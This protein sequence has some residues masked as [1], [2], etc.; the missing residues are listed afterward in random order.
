[1]SDYNLT[2][3]HPREFE[4]LTQSL[5]LR[6]ISSGVTPF[7]DGRDGGRE[8]TYTGKMM[9]PSGADQWDGYLVI[10]SKFLTRPTGDTGKDGDWVIEQL[11]KDLKKFEDPKRNLPKPEYYLLVTNVVLTPVH[12]VGSKDRVFKLLGNYEPKIGLKSYDVW[13]YDK[14]CRILDGQPEI[15]QRY[16]GF[17][18]TGDVLSQMAAFLQDQ[19]PDFSQI[20]SLFLQKELRSDQFVKLEQAGHTADQKTSLAHVFVDLPAFDQLLVEPPGDESDPNNLPAGIVAEILSAGSQMLKGSSFV[21][22][23]LLPSEVINELRPQPGRFV[24]VGGPGQGKSTIGQ[25]ICQLYRAAILKDQPPH[26]ISA[27][28]RTTLDLIGH[29]CHADGKGLPTVRRFP[30]RVVLDQFAN[31]L[32][33]NKVNS[34]LSYIVKR[35]NYLT[36]RMISPDDLRRWLGSYPWLI[37]LDGLDEVPATSNRNEVLEKIVEFWTEA[38]TLDADVL[39]VATTRP[40]GYNDDF[41]PR[42]YRHRYLAPLSPVR[43][44]FYAERLTE[45]RYG[46]DPDRKERVLKRLRTAVQQNTTNRLMRSPL[47]VTIMV[48]LV[49]KIGQP[50]QE[51]W[52]LFQ[53]YYEV[54]YQRETERDIPASRILQQRRS[55]VNAIHNR[56][57]LL[58]QTE[59]ERAGSTESRLPTARFRQL[60]HA[61][62]AQEGYE[63]EELELRTEEITEAALHRLVFLVGLESDLIGFEI[64]S[65]QEFTAAEALMDSID[66]QVRARL[67]AIAPSVHWRNVFLFAAGKCFAERQFLR[68]MIVG[69]CDQL[70]DPASDQLAGATLAGSRLALDILEDGVAREQPNFARSLARL[71]LRL[72]E[73]P[74]KDVNAR[75]A[76]V[77]DSS[78]ETMF[79]ERIIHNISQTHFVQSI[80]AWALLK[81]LIRREVPWAMELANAHWPTDLEQQYQII[82]LNNMVVGSWVLTKLID[83]IPK[84]V[85]W[86]VLSLRWRDTKEGDAGQQCTWLPAINQTRWEPTREKRI[87]VLFPLEPEDDNHTT[88]TIQELNQPDLVSLKDMPLIE[89]AW[90]PYL[91]AARFA[92]QPGSEN[93]AKEL[94]WLSKVWNPK[95]AHLSYYNFSWP[96]AA[97]LSACETV[98]ELTVLADKSSVGQLG[99]LEDWIEAEKRWRENGITFDDLKYLSDDLWPFDSKIGKIGFPFSCSKLSNSSVAID[100]LWNILWPQYESLGKSKASSVIAQVLL[101]LAS[102]SLINSSNKPLSITPNQLQDLLTALLEPQFKYS[103]LDFIDVPAVLNEEWVGF[104]EWLGNLPHQAYVGDKPWPQADQLGQAYSENPTRI[105][106]VAV[107]GVLAI[108]GS[109]CSV[110]E[111]LLT[112]ER[113]DI[114]KTQSMALFVRLA[115]GNWAEDATV[116]LAKD[117]AE[118]SK[119][120]NVID[121]ALRL[122]D[123]QDISE[124]AKESF[125]LALRDQLLVGKADELTKTI[126][127]LND[128][129]RSRSSQIH[130]LE[131]W[132]QLGLPALA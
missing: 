106:L 117:F 38:A 1:M 43:A 60:V 105:G 9:Y 14:L 20:M 25:F 52:R 127:P 97:C 24:I 87:Q 114:N 12:E 22:P 102:E 62:I 16:A 19:Q 125:I 10:Q 49:D 85:P 99:Q 69:I 61:R 115:Q 13:D 55:D 53:Q 80:G 95:H 71:A 54:I 40:Q 94:R 34:L 3:L 15:R 50:P 130:D 2:G 28:A 36:D 17:I 23:E 116:R 79:R 121:L 92:E 82:K 7:G 65:L 113:F 33:N 91:S 11:E 67:A 128:L 112:K 74:D 122:M 103:L 4:H 39:V 27:E 66:S 72:L 37:V 68:D 76:V 47:Q 32:A 41:S 119:E 84:T 6:L 73:L 26:T 132:K 8:A 126:E 86:K 104:F 45:T 110:P 56:V 93:L 120:S 109:K 123:K 124:Q 100:E 90:A 111:N 64:R 46:A 29:Q 118:H 18:T 35:I 78:L 83:I 21:A 88:F 131:R 108:A 129:M 107:L 58:L 31:D 42:L 59:S 44:L 81:D 5:A 70:N 89:P 75:L 98:E 30:V 51:R 48:T 96:L 77:Y 101:N 57:G 63:G